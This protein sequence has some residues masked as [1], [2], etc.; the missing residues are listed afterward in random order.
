MQCTAT[1]TRIEYLAEQKSRRR[2]L[3]NELVLS[4][5]PAWV[6]RQ[7]VSRIACVAEAKTCRDHA[8]GALSARKFL[9]HD[10]FDK[11]LSE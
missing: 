4:E 7:P 5:N 3:L 1:V 10:K 9:S 2:V 6:Y 11:I 8:C